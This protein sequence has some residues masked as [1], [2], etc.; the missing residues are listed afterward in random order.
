MDTIVEPPL[1][2]EELPDLPDLP[3]AETDSTD[4]KFDVS[5]YSGSHFFRLLQLLKFRFSL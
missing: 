1:P 5:S 3:V 4:Q 2:Y